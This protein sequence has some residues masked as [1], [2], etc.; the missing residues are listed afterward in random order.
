MKKTHSYVKRITSL[1]L[2]V[3]FVLT[4]F[5][6][7][8]FSNQTAETAKADN[9]EYFIMAYF[10]GNGD[11][12]ASIKE[13]QAIRFAVSADGE[14]FSALNGND[15]IIKQVGGT[16]NV[17][18]PYIFKGQDDYY[19][20]IGTDLDVTDTGFWG[21]QPQMVIWRS[22][23]LITWDHESYINSAQICG[24]NDNQVQRTW[25]PQVIWDTSTNKYM[26]Y[27]A[28]A[29]DGYQSTTMYYMLTD[30]LLDQS[31]Y[32]TPVSLY[33]PGADDIDADITYQDGV[34]YMFYK[35]ETTGRKTICLATATNCKG[36]YTYVGQ[37]EQ[38]SETGALE[39]CEVYKVGNNYY[40][41]ADRYGDNGKFAIYNLGTDLSAITADSSGVIAVT[42]GNPVSTINATSG[43]SNLTV[44]HGSVMHISKAQYDAL[45]DAYGGSSPDDI[46]FAFD[47]AYSV[48]NKYGYDAI[49]D[50][51]GYKFDIMTNTGKYSYIYPQ[52]HNVSLNGGNI[53]VN[54]GTIKNMFA[55]GK[56]WT[57]SFNVNLVQKIGSPLFTLTSG[58]SSSNNTDWLR[59]LDNGDFYVNNGSYT[60]IGSTDITTTTDYL[61]TITYDGTNVTLYK[62]GVKQF[63]SDVGTI[64]YDKNASTSYIAFGWSDT[65]G[66]S[67]GVNASY[68]NVRFR[69]KAITDADAAN[70]YNDGLI[71]RYNEGNHEDI[72]GRANVTYNSP[73]TTTTYVGKKGASYAISGW[74]NIGA[75][76]HNDG[77]LFEFGEGGT[78]NGKNYLTLLENGTIKWCW[79]EG[80]TPRY[81]DIDSIYDFA[82]DTYYYVQ[83][84]IIP[85]GSQ[86]HFQAFV[87]GVSVK[88]VT[89]GYNSMQTFDYGPINFFAG[90]R[91]LKFGQGSAYWTEAGYNIIDDIRVYNRAVDAAA[92]YA[93]VCEEDVADDARDYVRANLESYD[94]TAHPANRSAYHYTDVATGGFNNVV[95]SSYNSSACNNVWVDRSQSNYSSYPEDQ[96]AKFKDVHYAVFYPSNIVLMYDGVAANK[97]ALPV[98]LEMHG[99]ANDRSVVTVYCSNGNNAQNSS[100][101]KLAHYWTGDQNTYTTWTGTSKTY[102]GMDDPDEDNG[103]KTAAQSDGNSHIGYYPGSKYDFSFTVPND[104][105][106]HF[107]WNKL[108][109]TGTGNNSTYLE[110]FTGSDTNMRLYAFS[111]NDGGDFTIPNCEHNIYVINYK[112]IYDILKADSP[113]AVP[114]GFGG[115]GLKQFYTLFVKDNESNYTTDSLNQFY[116]AAAKV[117]KANPTDY[118]EA[119]YQKDFA[120]TAGKAAKEIKSAVDEFNNINLQARADFRNL[121]DAVADAQEIINN[122]ADNYTAASI[123]AIQDAVDA[124]TYLDYTAEQ[125]ANMAEADYQDAID[126]EETAIRTAIAAL[127][128]KKSVT[129]VE[130]G[131]TSTTVKFDQDVATAADVE[132]AAPS[133]P[134]NSYDSVANKHYTYAWDADFAA[135]TA[136]VTYTQVRN[137]VPHSYTYDYDFSD[138][139]Y[140]GNPADLA[141]YMHH[142]TC[143]VN[144]QSHDEYVEC[145]YTAV[146][147]TPPSGDLNGYTTYTCVCGRSYVEYDSLGYGLEQ[148]L[149]AVASY[150]EIIGAENYVPMYSAESRAAFEGRVEPLIIADDEVETYSDEFL[151]ERAQ[152]INSAIYPSE[153]DY[154][155]YHIYYHL[156]DSN[157][158]ELKEWCFDLP[159]TENMPWDE[160]PQLN[161]PLTENHYDDE[162]HYTYSWS[163]ELHDITSDEHYYEVETKTAH[164]Y[165]S[166]HTAADGD[167]NGYT[168]YTCVCGHSYVAYDAQDWT[169]YDAAV[170]AYDAADDD[171]KFEVTY[172]QAS[173]VAYAAAAS[174]KLTK[175]DTVS[176]EAIDSAT[177][178]LNAAVAGLEEAPD[179]GYNLTLK[180]DVEVNFYID[181][182]Y[183]D[184]EDGYITYSFLKDP[185]EFSAERAE[186]RIDDGSELLV[187]LPDG[188]RKLNIQVAP[189]QLAEKFQINVYDKDG[190]K[191]TDESIEASISGYC[192][193]LLES[194]A[195]AGYHQVVQALLDY[196]ALADEYFGYAAMSKSETGKD[197]EVPHSI[198][199]KDAIPSDTIEK[200]KTDGIA[201]AKFTA[202]NDASGN[203]I[204]IKNIS[205]VALVD[206]E[207]RFYV[208]QENQV[209]AALTDVSI[210]FE[211]P[212]V[213]DVEAKMVHTPN[214]NCVR[215]T[216]L[217][218][219]DFD[220]TF[221]I[222]IGEATLEYNG[223]AYLYTILKEGSSV[224]DTKLKD[225]AKGV[226]RYAI[227]CQAKFNS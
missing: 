199:Y 75:Y 208:T 63:T 207:F 34:Y 33:N 108:Y 76:K 7:V 148:Y 156:L 158:E 117:L 141:S 60:K 53:F 214:G 99:Y 181:T 97:P 4:T 62:D 38:K 212:T 92:N 162:Y 68:T 143:I 16:R 129:F 115:Y 81:V 6:V 15:P 45:I 140:L 56:S 21:N 102:S 54:D 184:A 11:A 5:A 169:A 18:D 22:A 133:L 69:S 36:P 71:Y 227:A 86:F 220:K 138:S 178:A 209:W 106:G 14:K 94:V 150:N 46:T 153:L 171:E 195:Y 103:G 190:N 177:A 204:G 112:P 163:P 139:G 30:N 167:A 187:E 173:R 119:A 219:C 161:A 111:G 50:A 137:E 224:T 77:V 131:G 19:Y 127:V 73:Q 197:Y 91:A 126:D 186:V 165:S 110:T 120:G 26:V 124:V 72:N 218:S 25:A 28:F 134:A 175:A 58:A 176:Q 192:E 89:S 170:A 123:S 215:V 217:K 189:A 70:D 159:Y 116:I 194:E 82:P 147:V 93:K 42:G 206:P 48:E 66:T 32:S 57:V 151:S 121:E 145:S 44:R 83:I 40:L 157:P 174:R 222:H 9:G 95:A 191:K 113:T 105:T 198:G 51:S 85:D 84:N 3:V 179:N 221:T 172:T 146:V 160:Y 202:G 100:N 142:Q 149:G 104:N 96:Q 122:D 24:L 135:P 154:Q 203:T 166:V 43:F 10:T 39:G 59:F 128:A 168:T 87:D 210:E 37:L 136:D 47:K 35:D 74:V 65:V 144:G 114:N 107:F 101:F 109:Y 185:A 88:D 67:K 29:A 90:N 2:S 226:Y 98:Q 23:D 8:D 13:N 12:E 225:L 1:F 118:T 49:N 41:M 78:G 130:Y 125:R 180:D 200:L 164:S 17:R 155:I 211:D 31:H 183:Y 193:A 79:S 216:G 80:S 55:T 201:H 64:N 196:G 205:Y 223:Y 20:L 27:F 61:F 182:E 132:A 52:T 213:T 188:R 152:Q